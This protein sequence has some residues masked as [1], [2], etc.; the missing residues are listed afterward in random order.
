MSRQMSATVLEKL[1]RSF[2][3]VGW[4]SFWIQLALA[5]VP[6]FVFAYTIYS[7]LIGAVVRYGLSHYLAFIGLG[8]LVFTTIWSL[9]YV[10]FGKRIRD[11]E[12]RPTRARINRLLWVGLWAGAMGIVVSVL[13]LIVNVVW[14]L[15][16]FLKAPQGGVP[17]IQTQPNDRTSWVSAID[18]VSLLAQVSTL[19][20]ELIVLGLTLWLLFRMAH[21]GE[22]YEDSMGESISS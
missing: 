19:T 8:I 10:R 11:V 12:R 2:V 3:R 14:L 13:S 16:L 7:K 6:A 15:V 21:W 20:G 22:T 17:V 18:A 5:L 4:V 9:R 1:S